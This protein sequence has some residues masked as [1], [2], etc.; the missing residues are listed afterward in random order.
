VSARLAAALAAALAWPAA[1]GALEY[2]TPMGKWTIG[3][4]GELYSVFRTNHNTQSQRPAGITGLSL[5]GDVHPKVRLFL[6]GQFMAGGWPENATGFDLYN[7]SDTFQ[8]ISPSTEVEEGY[9]DVFLGAVDLRIGKQKFAWGKLDTFQP[10]DVLNTRWYNDPFLTDEQDAKIGVP[11]LQAAWYLPALGERLPQD[12]S[13]TLVWI[14]I[15][16][17]T[18][19]PVQ[20][21]RWFPPA[22]EVARTIDVS[23]TDVLPENP[24][25]VANDVEE[26]NAQPKQA[27]DEGAVGLKLTGLWGPVDWDL[28]YYNGIETDPVLAFAPT[29]VYPAAR[30]AIRQGEP[31]PVPPPGAPLRL[32]A[33]SALIP[34]FER[35]QLFGADGSYELAGFTMRG[36]VAYG[37]DRLLPR[38]VQELVADEN[39]QR[40]IG[41]PARQARLAERLFAGRRVPLPLGDLFA[42]SDTVEWG[43]GVDYVLG[44]W[45]PLVQVNQT[46]VLD[47][48]PTLLIEDV[49]TQ[50]LFALRRAFLDERLGTELAVIQSVSRGYTVGIARAAYDVTD[51][52]RVRVG[53]LLLAG[54][55]NSLYG[56]FHSNDE[57]F[58]RIRYS[59]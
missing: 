30:R 53:Y 14:P 28:Y 22:I 58:L 5:T 55:R 45:M 40:A 41:G 31:P 21:E 16:I 51:H 47:D 13:A 7:I 18:R 38:S 44:A 39:V 35:I 19:F 32:A 15:P 25:V 12:V 26:R 23:P 36:E 20:E 49:D 24:I 17:S 6:S 2:T 59:F 9:V 43:V 57:A 34:R 48:V 27:L 3:G 56:Q 50:F 37:L 54:S 4:Y 11:A 52:L 29:L 42:T 33:D 8:N 1:A 46:I 10:T